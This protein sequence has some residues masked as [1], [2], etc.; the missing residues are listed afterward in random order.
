MKMI[1]KCIIAMAILP[2]AM[3]SAFAKSSM[4]QGDMMS[5][6]IYSKLD[7]SPEQ[8]QQI[9]IRMLEAKI[10][11]V[12]LGEIDKKAHQQQCLAMLK[13]KAFDEKKAQAMI[14]GHQAEQAKH[15]L[16]M[17]KA[18][19]DAFQILTSTQQAQFEV[20]M[21]KMASPSKHKGKGHGQGKGLGKGMGMN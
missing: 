16:I 15:K 2:F 9:K 13:E 11:Q 18:R 21:Q 17:L 12:K 7:L 20:L 14:A 19:H 1:S 4:G 5:Q 3:Q 8:A 6:K 10:E